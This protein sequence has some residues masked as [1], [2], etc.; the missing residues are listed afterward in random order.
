MDIK[1][2][3]ELNTAETAVDR[4]AGAGAVP[5][6]DEDIEGVA[7]GFGLQTV[8]LTV[9]K[10]IEKTIGTDTKNGSKGSKGQKTGGVR[11]L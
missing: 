6:D 7:G 3:N 2:K 8:D 5:L 1:K 9:K 4:Y 11:R 10:N